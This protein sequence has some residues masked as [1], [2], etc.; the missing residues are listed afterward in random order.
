MN[1]TTLGR[2]F[3]EQSMLVSVRWQ[4]EPDR[5]G[6]ELAVDVYEADKWGAPRMNGDEVRARGRVDG[7][8]IVMARGLSGTGALVDVINDVVE[9][10]ARK[11][12]HLYAL[13]R[14]LRE[15]DRALFALDHD[16]G[17]GEEVASGVRELWSVSDPDTWKAYADKR[18]AILRW[19]E[20]LS[21]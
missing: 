8:L 5:D 14:T 20:V 15:A 9:D 7:R 10:A 3:G 19:I 1:Q 18:D 11:A 16:G 2:I 13:R 6:Y 21:E 12:F 17:H 4:E